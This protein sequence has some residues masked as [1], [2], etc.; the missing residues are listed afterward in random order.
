MKRLAFALCLLSLSLSA[1][2]AEETDGAD[3]WY[4]GA[5]ASLV[6]PQGGAHVRRLGGAG[7]RVGRYLGEDW[8]IEGD[9]AWLEDAAGLSVDALWHLQGWSAYGDLFGYSR[10]D[11]FL[12]GGVKGWVGRSCGQVGPRLGLGAFYHLTDSWS[13]RGDA[14]ATLGLDTACEMVYTLSLGV[15]YSF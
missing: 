6:L 4:A 5:S 1:A 14:D 9:A 8:A 15:Q 3:D 12:T 13:L 10:F 11:P 7:F 2:E